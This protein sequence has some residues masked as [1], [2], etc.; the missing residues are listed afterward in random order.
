MNTMDAQV[1]TR[2]SNLTNTK[3]LLATTHEAALPAVQHYILPTLMA[4]NVI[5]LKTMLQIIACRLSQLTA[6][7]KC[8]VTKSAL[9]LLQV[10]FNITIYNSHNIINQLGKT[11][12]PTLR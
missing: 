1:L 8:M 2:H 3:Q 12:Q 7:A 4:C 10:G 11:P 5:A 9:L 6:T